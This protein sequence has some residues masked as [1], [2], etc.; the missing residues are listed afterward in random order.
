M[1]HQIACSK[2]LSSKAY[3]SR[4]SIL[5]FCELS[6]R[7]FFL[8]SHPSSF[9]LKRAT[10]GTGSANADK[11][12]FLC[13]KLATLQCTSTIRR[14][15]PPVDMVRWKAYNLYRHLDVCSSQCRLPAPRSKAYCECRDAKTVGVDCWL[16][17]GKSNDWI[18]GEVY[19]LCIKLTTLQCTSTIRVKINNRTRSQDTIIAYQKSQHETT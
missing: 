3:F 8:S 9:Q 19:F 11:S 14:I 7:S 18:V 5:S 10:L 1:W 17:R 12:C 6:P 4:G 15:I 16:D 2:R 13:I